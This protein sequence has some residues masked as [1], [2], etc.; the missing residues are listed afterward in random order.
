M[1][2]TPIFYLVVAVLFVPRYV[3]ESHVKAPLLTTM[4]GAAIL[5]ALLALVR[6]MSVTDAPGTDVNSP[7][8]L[9]SITGTLFGAVIV[10]IGSWHWLKSAT[11]GSKF[12]IF[13]WF[14]LIFVPF[15]ILSLII[16]DYEAIT[17]SIASFC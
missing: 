1:L 11:E 5:I 10:L 16:V 9:A 4:G 8:A 14:L 2:F 12:P 7:Y 3:S 15:I 17:D 6:S 13:R